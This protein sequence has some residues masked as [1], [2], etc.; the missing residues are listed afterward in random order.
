MVIRYAYIALVAAATACRQP[1]EAEKEQIRQ[2][3]DTL[4]ERMRQTGRQVDSVLRERAPAIGDTIQQR[5][6]I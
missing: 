1:T 4:G 3:I 2:D 6:K 5:M